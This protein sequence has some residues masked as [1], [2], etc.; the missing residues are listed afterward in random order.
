VNAPDTIA[1]IQVPDTALARAVTAYVRGVEDDLL[2]HHSRRVYFFGALHGRRRGLAPDLDLLYAGAMFHDVG[3]TEI[4]AT[5]SSQR[6][7]VDSADAVERFLLGHGVEPTLARRVW[8]G[9]ALHTTPEIPEH[10]E[11]EVALVTAG[12]ETD[13]LGIGK[14]ALA[15]EDVEAVTTAHPRPDF[16]RRIVRAF[17]TGMCQ[18]P[19]TTFGTVNADVLAHFVPGFTRQ[20]FVE[21]IQG[22]GWPE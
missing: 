8:L 12:V 22:S 9:V 17:A 18:R 14:D 1:G 13:V 4:Y 15:V 21:V 16:K 20:D 2:F 3:L 19:S 6:F 7:E 10:L 5:T 11:S